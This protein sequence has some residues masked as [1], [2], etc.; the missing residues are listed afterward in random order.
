MVEAATHP[1]LDEAYYD[2]VATAYRFTDALQRLTA[3]YLEATKYP[4]HPGVAQAVRDY[5]APFLHIDGYPFMYY[6]ARGPQELA[7]A[8]VRVAAKR[9]GLK[10]EFPGATTPPPTCPK[11]GRKPTFDRYCDKHKS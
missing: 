1:L 9:L 4:D 6:E 3:A 2:C 10:P 5:Q 8:A 7:A 11:C